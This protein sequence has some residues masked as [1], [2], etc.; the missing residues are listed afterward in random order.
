MNDK[1]KAK[2]TESSQGNQ[3]L[4]FDRTTSFMILTQTISVYSQAKTTPHLA[5]TQQ[6]LLLSIQKF[7]RSLLQYRIGTAEEEW[8]TLAFHTGHGMQPGVAIGGS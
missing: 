7:V 3:G 1:R 5:I 8:P 6:G 4:S 2:R